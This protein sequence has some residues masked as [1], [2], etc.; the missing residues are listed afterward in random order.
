MIFSCV[1]C[2]CFLLT[3]IIVFL[4][5]FIT[6]IT[7]FPVWCAFV[8]CVYIFFFL[9]FSTNFL[10]L[11]RAGS[12]YSPLFCVFSSVSSFILSFSFFWGVCLIFFVI[13]LVLL[14]I[15]FLFQSSHLLFFSYFRVLV[16]VPVIYPFP[17]F[18]CHIPNFAVVFFPPPYCLPFLVIT[19][20]M[21]HFSVCLRY[22]F[23]RLP[24][25]S[26]PRHMPHSVVV[27][28]LFPHTCHLSS[29]YFSPFLCVV[30]YPSPFPPPHLPPF[31]PPTPPCP[32]R[33]FS[34]SFF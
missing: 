7:F 18:L 14:V 12:Y 2:N 22:C 1:F 19:L 6:L 25:P 13:I 10:F 3:F 8:F 32:V 11:C 29:L 23:C 9:V 16:I 21:L 20:I 28:I 34:L 15:V 26:S 33:S 27:F 24:F 31:L 5:L 30:V 4:L 17:S